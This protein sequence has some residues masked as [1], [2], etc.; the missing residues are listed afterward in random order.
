M[1]FFGKCLYIDVILVDFTQ[2]MMQ[3]TAVKK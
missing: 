3:I 1:I 2:E